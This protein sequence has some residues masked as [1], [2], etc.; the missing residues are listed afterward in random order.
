MGN[1]VQANILGFKNYFS[2]VI[3]INA[4]WPE[5]ARNTFKD[6]C[7]VNLLGT[8]P[9]GTEMDAYVESELLCKLVRNRTKGN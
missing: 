1:C 3:K 9:K 5:I 4:N 7:C 6:S 8:E 2:H